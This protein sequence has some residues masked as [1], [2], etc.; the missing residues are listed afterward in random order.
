MV[1]VTV[2]ELKHHTPRV[3]QLSQRKGP[4]VV[5]RNGRPVAVL[6]TA[7]LEDLALQFKGLWER[8]RHAADRA[9]FRR[10]DVE[11]LIAQVRAERA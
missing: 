6:R 10:R 2:R 8:L 3:L 9:G 1:F 4:V 7:S 5:T 11:R